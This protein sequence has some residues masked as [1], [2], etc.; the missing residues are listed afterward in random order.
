MEL[1]FFAESFASALIVIKGVRSVRI[2]EKEYN[3]TCTSSN[4]ADLVEWRQ[5]RKGQSVPVKSCSK[6]GIAAGAVCTCSCGKISAKTLR[7][8]SITFNSAG[9]FCCI[10]RQIDGLRLDRELVKN[11]SV[12][13]DT[14]AG[15]CTDKTN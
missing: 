12:S 8:G 10:Q 13:I 9:L 6:D 3:I 14:V 5:I 15:E 7:F 4:S 1:I 11:V 2:G